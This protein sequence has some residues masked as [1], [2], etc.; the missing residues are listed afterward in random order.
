MWVT[1]GTGFVGRQIVAA[2]QRAGADIAAPPPADLLDPRARRVAVAHAKASILIH[3]A[4]FTRPGAYWTAPE[5]LDWCAATLDLVRLFAASGGRRIVLTGSCAEYDWTRPARTAWRETKPCRPATV[6]GAAKLAAWIAVAAFAR[7][8]AMSAATA[9]VFTPVGRHEAP[10][11]LLP[12]L[13]RAARA[14][15]LLDTGPAGMTRDFIDVRDAGEAIAQLALSGAEGP[16]NVGSGRAVSIG[17]LARL[18][19]GDQP[20]IHPTAR[21]KRL[22]EP[23]WMVADIA[24]LRRAT[25]YAPRYTLEDTVADAV[26][27]WR[28]A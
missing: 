6:Y 15:V 23:S 12:C 27:Q 19:A 10:E 13:I 20:L 3:A 8:S 21:P 11:R 2:L 7:Q 4:W 22:G 5:N 14:G 1:G 24:R 26:A 17:E 16:F 28:A 18:V 9:R 25:G